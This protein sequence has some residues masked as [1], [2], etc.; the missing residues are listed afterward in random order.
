MERSLVRKEVMPFLM[1]F[2][3]LILATII[4]DAI[5]HLLGFTWIGRWLG[6]PGTILIL[7]SFFYSMRKR[8]MISFGKPKT[9]LILHETLTWMGALM[10]LVH[11]GVHIY[12][13]LPWLALIAMLI[14]VI[15][16]MTGKYL[17]DRSRRH[18]SEKKAT[19]LQQ[20]LSEQELEKKLFWDATTFDVMKKWRVVHLPITLAFAVL[21]IAH[22]L[23]IFLFWQ[24]G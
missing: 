20:G 1:M 18:M 12:S 13:I 19:Y 8:K 5:L 21:G 24:W 4:T 17:L 16:G 15:S 6:I 2:G 10:I 23:S 7:L 14:N 9:L 22:I 3:S 11:A